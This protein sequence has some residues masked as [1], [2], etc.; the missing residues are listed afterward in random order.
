M[1]GNAAI[2]GRQAGHAA[3]ADALAFKIERNA[4]VDQLMTGQSRH[5]F[6]PRGGWL[7]RQNA[8]PVMFDHK[9]NVGPC[10]RKPLHRVER[11]G[12][13]GARAAQEF[14]P[15][16]HIAEQVFNAHACALRQGGWPFT[17]YHAMV[18]RSRP[19]LGTCGPAFQRHFGHAC[20]RGQSLPPETQSRDHF[21]IFIRQFRCRMAFKRQC[22]IRWRHAAPIIGDFDQINAACTQAHRYIARTRIDGVFHQ[23]L[24]RAGRSFHHFTGGNPV[25]QIFGEPSY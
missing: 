8:P 23:F 7:H 6:R 11:C 20:N 3:K 1:V 9:A 17:R 2:I 13:F 15:C 21:N 10:H 25:D 22:H 19:A 18:H 5:T 24:Q 12:I 14:A 4:V 16:G